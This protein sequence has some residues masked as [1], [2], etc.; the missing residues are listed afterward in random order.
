MRDL[1]NNGRQSIFSKIWTLR[2]T[3]VRN[4]Y[5]DKA[6]ARGEMAGSGII[7]LQVWSFF[8]RDNICFGCGHN[9]RPE[10]MCRN[11]D[12]KIDENEG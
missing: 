5:M 3:V 2:K 10:G 7:P 6:M 12:T 11:E 1:N 9:I 8:R 4:Q